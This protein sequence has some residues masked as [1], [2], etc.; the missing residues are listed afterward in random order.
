MPRWTLPVVS[1]VALSLAVPS[2]A[3]AWVRFGP[4]AVLG[5]VA[6]LMIGG[7]R[8]SSRH[9]RHQAVH[10]S[11]SQRSVARGE[12]RHAA[13]VARAAAGAPLAAANAPQSPPKPPPEV[14]PE[15]SAA[16]FWPDAAA[17]LADYVLF[18]NGNDRFWSYGYDTIV[19]AAFSAP[20]GADQRAPRGRPAAG[21]L[22]DA[23]SQV[24]TPL[25]STD[26]C[27]GTSASA[28]ALMERIERAVSPNASQRD[29]LEQLRRAL[30]QAIERIAATC[31]AVVPA[32]LAER[33]NAIQNRI[34][35]MRNALL[36]IRLPLETFYT[37]LSDEQR[38]RLQ[39]GEPQPAQMTAD[40]TVGRGQTDRSAPTCAEPAA[41]T[42]DWIMRAIERAAPPSGGQ[43]AGLEAMRLRSAAMAQLI[44]ASCPGD[45]QLDP[46]RRFAAATD[47]L[48][49]LLFAVMSMSPMLQQLY[50]SLDDK[51]K[52]GLSRALSQ[53]RRSASAGARS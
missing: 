39:Q 40:A 28:D 24:K 37:S 14:S 26:L 30:A 46:M 34:W 18:A 38:Q 21:Q 43:R 53:A 25:A 16:I 8:H 27:G 42:A 49:L 45:A 9:H 2:T 1:A 10:A 41:G 20:A 44:A 7:F 23:A 15:R 5:A 19:A 51:Q 48:D 3:D 33:L 6:G 47:R 12:R 17:D 4:G 32:S 50:D 52:A 13:R 31:P 22:S 11:A 36:T 35:A 29:A